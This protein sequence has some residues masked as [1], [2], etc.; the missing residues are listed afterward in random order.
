MTKLRPRVHIFRNL[1]NFVITKKIWRK[2]Q[3]SDTNRP[4]MEPEGK[5]YFHFDVLGTSN[6]IMRHDRT[7]VPCAQYSLVAFKVAKSKC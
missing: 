2:S 1:Y 6:T 3:L 5:K 4:K 7:T